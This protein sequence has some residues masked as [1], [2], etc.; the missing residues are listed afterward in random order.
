MVC[1]IVQKKQKNGIKNDESSKVEVQTKKEEILEKKEN[2]TKKMAP[3]LKRLIFRASI[4]RAYNRKCH[5]CE[6]LI[7]R[8][9]NMEV[10]HI[11]PKKYKNRPEEFE[12][13][14]KE[15]ELQSDFD[16]DAYYNRAPAHK[17]C[18]V[19][20]SDHLYQKRATLYYIEEAIIKIPKIEEYE[21]ELEENVSISEEMLEGE[22]NY[23]K[24]R[25]VFEMMGVSNEEK[26]I[27]IE[28]INEI[29]LQEHINSFNNYLDIIR[30]K[31]PKAFEWRYYKIRAEARKVFN[32]WD[33]INI[34]LPVI[35]NLIKL[36]DV[37]INEENKI[38]QN[39]GID[40]LNLLT[41][42]PNLLQIIIEKSYDQLISHYEPGILNQQLVDL[43]VKCE[44]FPD[45]T[46]PEIIYLIKNQYV[47][48]LSC[49]KD[50]L[51][52]KKFTI[53]REKSQLYINDITLATI[54]LEPRTNQSHKTIIQYSNEV[55]ELLN[56]IE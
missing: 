14:K 48:P 46:I 6:D 37:F 21:K 29:T 32:Y 18:N 41:T 39:W 27:I 26:P 49:F 55:K 20:K 30:G 25:K 52:N 35:D 23:E 56:K 19:K 22:I 11:I 2:K 36:M 24:L 28:V 8:L 45:D 13:I 54:D 33:K 34:D 15:Y 31:G 51:Y 47:K 10:D 9:D 53:S 1:L 3:Q 42:A 16:I 50:R 17:G 38:L 7:S 43:L 4:W 12:K 40:I 44:Y 5:Y